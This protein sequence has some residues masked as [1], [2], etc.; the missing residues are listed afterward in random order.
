MQELVVLLLN[1]AYCDLPTGLA[2]DSA[3]RP[4]DYPQIRSAAARRCRLFAYRTSDDR[5]RRSRS[6]HATPI[7]PGRETRR[8][9]TTP[10]ETSLPWE[11]HPPN[12]HPD[13]PPRIAPS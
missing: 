7:D 5:E 12:S 10:H 9:R 8:C 11:H 4:T 6:P 13:E 1:T 2:T 3:Q